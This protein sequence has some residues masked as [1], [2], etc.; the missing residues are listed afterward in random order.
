[1]F[2][3]EKKRGRERA[4][5]SGPLVSDQE[6]ERRRQAVVYC[7]AGQVEAQLGRE[8]VGPKKERS[9]L[10]MLFPFYEILKVH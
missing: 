5:R 3:R 10:E 8:E 7:W 6:R 9:G 1:M 4:D 2:G